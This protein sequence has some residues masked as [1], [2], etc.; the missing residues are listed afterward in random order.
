VRRGREW[1]GLGWLGW[2]G[3]MYGWMDGLGSIRVERTGGRAVSDQQPRA[4]HTR[5]TMSNVTSGA[6]VLAASAASS[7]KGEGEDEDG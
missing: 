4:K 7:S 1:A 2:D 3:W 5:A 6:W